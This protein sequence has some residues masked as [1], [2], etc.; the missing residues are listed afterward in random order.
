MMEKTL[1][2]RLLEGKQVEYEAVTYPDTVGDAEVVAK[3][4]GVPAGQL[5]K[6]LVVIRP[7]AKPMLVMVPA[8]QQLALKRLAKA[9]GAKK[10]K[11]ATHRQAEE[12]TGLQ[13]GGISPLALLNQGF[14]IYLDESARTHGHIYISAGQRGINLKVGVEDLVK[15]TAARFVEATAAERD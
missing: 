2:M 12:L 7:F 3:E 5:F 1:A 6:T 10:L 9:V 14:S 8:D 11:M 4:L 13:V 15:V